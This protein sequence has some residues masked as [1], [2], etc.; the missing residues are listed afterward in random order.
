MGLLTTPQHQFPQEMKKKYRRQVRPGK[1]A[2]REK[3]QLQSPKLGQ[4]QF[5]MPVLFV[6]ES[7]LAFLT[8]VIFGHSVLVG[9]A[10]FHLVIRRFGVNE[11]HTCQW[12]MLSA[13]TSAASDV[14][15]MRYVHSRLF[16][17]L[18]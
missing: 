9:S 5:L 6:A 14:T 8:E 15:A 11:V 10:A 16:F 2:K 3:K 17:L 7:L 18:G 13:K 1:K 12:E 4:E